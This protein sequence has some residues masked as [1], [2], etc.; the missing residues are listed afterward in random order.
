MKNRIRTCLG[1]LAL[2]GVCLVPAC[3]NDSNSGV[4]PGTLSGAVVLFGNFDPAYETYFG[5][6]AG[7]FELRFGGIT[8]DSVDFTLDADAQDP[9]LDATAAGQVTIDT[10]GVCMFEFTSYQ[11]PGQPQDRTYSCERRVDRTF[12]IVTL[13]L[14]DDRD[15]GSTGATAEGTLL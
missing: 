4:S 7:V 1:L 9:L 13:R 11:G 5:I 15:A 2:A 10:N 8:G 14:T 12:G 6:A 3:D